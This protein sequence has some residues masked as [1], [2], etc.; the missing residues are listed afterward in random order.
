MWDGVYQ[1]LGLNALLDG[2]G[3]NGARRRRNSVE[4]LEVVLVPGKKM[5]LHATVNR[6]ADP[7]DV[8]R[9]RW[10]EGHADG[11]HGSG[12]DPA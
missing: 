5:P 12:A 1:R 7:G 8:G 2:T 11:R 3:M 4:P 10:L 6:P 9:L